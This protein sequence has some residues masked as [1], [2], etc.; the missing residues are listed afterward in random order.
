MQS[1]APL[2][3]LA[4][5]KHPQCTH[6]P[7]AQARPRAGM[8]GGGVGFVQGLGLAPLTVLTPDTGWS[9]PS[10]GTHTFPH[11]PAKQSTIQFSPKQNKGHTAMLPG[12]A[13][14]RSPFP[15]TG[16]PVRGSGSGALLEGACGVGGESSFHLQPPKSQGHRDPGLSRAPHSPCHPGH[17]PG[18]LWPPHL[19]SKMVWCHGMSP[20]VLVLQ[21]SH[22][23]S[24]G[25]APLVCHPP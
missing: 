24:K 17:V 21:A 2:T 20:R 4:A 10:R 8:D 22:H 25:R 3:F 7:W 16:P 6:G 11:T 5:T 14:S 18:P 12:A 19:C 23:P 1:L 13:A 15:G 9:R